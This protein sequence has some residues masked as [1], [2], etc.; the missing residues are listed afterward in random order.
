MENREANMIIGDLN[1]NNRKRVTLEEWMEQ[2]EM[3][4]IGIAE[5]IYK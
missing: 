1:H 4:D 2:E 5:Y 3:Q